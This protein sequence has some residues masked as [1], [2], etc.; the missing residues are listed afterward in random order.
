MRA[1]EMPLG[2]LRSPPSLPLLA[3]IAAPLATLP[4][5]SITAGMISRKLRPL[6]DLSSSTVDPSV[7]V[8]TAALWVNG[9]PV[10]KA[11]P[12]DQASVAGSVRIRPVNLLPKPYVWS[13]MP[14]K[15]WPVPSSFTA[16]I[17]LF[18]PV[19]LGGPSICAAA[20]KELSVPGLLAA[21]IPYGCNWNAS[22]PALL[23][24]IPTVGDP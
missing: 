22:A 10:P 15:S 21:K 8:A 17:G 11:S 1:T 5:F 2:L 7:A 20:P 9:S 4:S 12:L 3:T 16:K 23:P 14:W 19:S 13:S 6:S 18:M 24:P